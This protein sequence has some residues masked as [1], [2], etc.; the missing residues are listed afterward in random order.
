[1]PRIPRDISGRKLA[2]LLEKKYRYKITRETGSHIRLVSKFEN[3]EH[4]IT[5]PDHH[6]I[7][8][9]TLNNI[10]N[11]LAGNIAITKEELISKLF[12]K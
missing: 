11:D 10:L 2:K 8:I 9:G 6:A 4:R 12:D 3:H 5:I 7:K 1:M